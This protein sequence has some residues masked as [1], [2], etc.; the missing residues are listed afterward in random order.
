MACTV[1][2]ALKQISSWIAMRWIEQPQVITARQRAASM[3]VVTHSRTKLAVLVPVMGH[4]VHSK[5]CA[6]SI[7]LRRFRMMRIERLQS[8]HM[9]QGIT[10]CSVDNATNGNS[11][12]YAYCGLDACELRCEGQAGGE[13]KAETFP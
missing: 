12:Y 6:R 11:A 13:A 10:S 3:R 9:Y 1:R 2:P 7:A 4:F 8:V 5:Q